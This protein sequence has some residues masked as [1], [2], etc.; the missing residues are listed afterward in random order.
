MATKHIT[1]GVGGVG[2]S[3]IAPAKRPATLPTILRTPYA[4]TE[5]T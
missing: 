4:V 5:K 3:V 2:A 1:I